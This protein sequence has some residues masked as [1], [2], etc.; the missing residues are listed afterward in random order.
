[1]YESIEKAWEAAAS[2]PDPKSDLGY[3]H[4]PLTVIHVDEA[5]EWYMFLPGEEDHL[6]D[7]E[8]LIAKPDSVCHPKDWR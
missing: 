6:T 7:S 3:E 4:D 5:Q 2:N 1:M 8:F